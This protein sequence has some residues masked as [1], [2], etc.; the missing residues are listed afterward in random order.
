[1]YFRLFC[2]WFRED[3]RAF[4]KKKSK[5]KE[6]KKILET[7]LESKFKNAPNALENSLKLKK[8]LNF[9]ERNFKKADI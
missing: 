5:T 4:Q 7:N 2:K 3:S 6:I 8:N 1:M 9:L